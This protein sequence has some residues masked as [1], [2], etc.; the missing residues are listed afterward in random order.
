MNNLN[1]T[2]QDAIYN[3][4]W[5]NVYWFAR[6]LLNS[7]QY[8]SLGKKEVLMLELAN[9]LD[10]IL[11]QSGLTDDEKITVCSRILNDKI[12][13]ASK[14]GSKIS[15]LYSDFIA[16]VESELKTTLD[17]IVFVST[18]KFVVL[19]ANSALNN[20][21]SDDVEFSRTTAKNILDGL[22]R[23]K[24]GTV[25]SVWD[26][27]GVR[28]CL[29]IERREIVKEFTS[30]K[31]NLSALNVPRTE[32]EDNM[33]LTAFVQEFE[34]RAG[35]KR[36]AR[37]GNSLEDISTFLFNYYGFTSS[38]GP[39]HFQSD[40]EVD[41]WFKCKDG[42]LIGISCKRTIRERWKQVSSA[43]D[44][45]LSMHKIKE[46]WHLMTYDRDLSD[47]KITMLGK[48]R[49]VFYLSDESPVYK[50]ASE[51]KGMSSYVRPLSQLID[52]IETE[53]KG[54]K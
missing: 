48:Q 20:I 29:D 16:A 27:L 12:L 53:Q 8:G 7:D 23:S 51:H 31:S 47:D 9:E 44:R 2:V 18:I 52:D 5:K 24:A 54:K 13:G 40:I 21:P 50:R 32:I 37:A 6:M 1:D 15:L 17:W 10:V 28:G 25:I 43:D 30:L 46:I 14:K 26:N 3:S 35:Q 19:P 11:G 34:R 33:I 36:K 22:G 45:T 4:P 41:K 49:H 38:K 39:D 42:W